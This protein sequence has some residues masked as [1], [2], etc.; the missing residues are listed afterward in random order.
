MR[1]P[2]NLDHISSGDIFGLVRGLWRHY[3]KQPT[4]VL[5]I[6]QMMIDFKLSDRLLWGSVLL[7]LWRLK[8]YRTLLRLLQ[9]LSTIPGLCDVNAARDGS[10]NLVKLW[11][12]VLMVPLN[13]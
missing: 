13:E 11:Q 12:Q 10:S 2:F 5:L 3:R 8:R 1:L 6:A 4:I 7:E 9:P